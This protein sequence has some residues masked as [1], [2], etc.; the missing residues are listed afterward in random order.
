MK[1]SITL[2]ILGKPSYRPVLLE[3]TVMQQTFKELCGPLPTP[4]TQY[5]KKV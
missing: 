5:T 4:T 1:N 2:K 3:D